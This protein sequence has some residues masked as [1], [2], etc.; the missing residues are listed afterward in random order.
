MLRDRAVVG[1]LVV[2]VLAGGAGLGGLAGC[3]GSGY[4]FVENEDL[5][6]YARVPDDW[7]LYD[8]EDLLDLRIDEELSPEEVERE[9]SGM[10]YRGFDSD[11][12]EP[13]VQFDPTGDSPSGFVR[14]LPLTPSLREQANLTLLRMLPTEGLLPIS[15]T[16]PAP[17][18]QVVLDEP[19]EFDGG[20][21]GVH[22]VVA[23]DQGEVVAMLDQTVLL[24]STSSIAYMFMVGCDR[25]CYLDTH[26]DEIEDIVDSWTIQED[27]R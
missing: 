12:E 16:D 26:G 8:E 24:D 9:T 6:V 10:F 11:D 13:S 15:V 3:G 20:Y 27:G 25:H 21:H 1:G 23:L 18:I 17:G 4:Q 19:V 22:T 2:G 7:A 5:G 14:V